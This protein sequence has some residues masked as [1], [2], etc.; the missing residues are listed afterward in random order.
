MS[1][2][3]RQKG[4]RP[5]GDLE[6]LAQRVT[7]NPE[8]YELRWRLAKKLYMAWEYNDALK[9]LL[10]L[11]KNWSRKLNVHRYL[12]ATFY[13]LGRHDEAISELQDTLRHWPAEVSVWEQL[14]RVCEVAERHDDASEAWNQIR[15]LNPAHPAAVRSVQR[16]MTPPEDSARKDLRL[17]DSDSGINLARY[18]VC[19][20]CGA[21]NS[22]EFERC[23]Q[24]HAA[25]RRQSSLDT[26]TPHVELVEAS[27][28]WI[29]T[30]IGGL[31]TVS[32]LSV[33]T[34]LVFTQW[35]KLPLNE[36]PLPLETLNDALAVQL[37][38]P[39]LLAAVTL[40]VCCPVALWGGFRLFGESPPAWI[41]L[42]GAGALIAAVTYAAS[43]M[44][45]EW[46]AYAPLLPLLA[47][48][49][50]V[51]ALSRIG[52]GKTLGIW[53]IQL[54]VIAVVVGGCI[55]AMAGGE[56]LRELPKI[57]N[58]HKTAAS[59]ATPPMYTLVSGLTPIDRALVWQ[60]TEV[61]W[62]NMYANRVVLEFDFKNPE[63]P[64]EV[65]IKHG[66]EV[67]AQV[68][69]PP[70]R[71]TMDVIP[72]HTYELRIRSEEPVAVRG[73]SRGILV[74]VREPY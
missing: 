17:G 58:A 53:A 26:D 46:I 31:S 51:I 52:W 60:K 62:I 65:E 23:W 36:D 66:T 74:P 61:S 63:I 40:L 3:A 45:L 30:L 64:I 14:A 29:W 33:C 13:R 73:V 4:P 11:R 47:A 10:V 15:R 1:E 68:S 56:L 71:F 32:A 16:L 38:I 8:D 41:S 37:F 25:L 44:P 35:G 5:T 12:A 7:M 9:H 54:G 6:E 34:Y 21:Q 18:R 67:V 22:E 50:A 70:Y 24:C 57:L 19:R 49:G 59:V 42:V 72:E 2:Q 28:P 39:K 48:F 43:W 69:K 55:T 20:N 27:V